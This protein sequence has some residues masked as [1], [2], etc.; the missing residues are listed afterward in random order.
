MTR[1]H[2]ATT[3]TAYGVVGYEVVAVVAPDFAT[4]GEDSK[5][6]VMVVA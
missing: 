1:N 4:F 5:V 3:L 2:A 6:R